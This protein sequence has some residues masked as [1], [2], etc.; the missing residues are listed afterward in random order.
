[1]RETLRRAIA[2]IEGPQA[3][4][5][6]KAG[7]SPGWH[8]GCPEADRL[9]PASGLE[10]RGVHEVKAV[11]EGRS[12]SAAAWMTS[13][14]FALRLAA[15]RVSALETPLPS[16]SQ[17]S[18]APARPWLMWCWP[19]HLSREFG[20]P[21]ALGLKRLSLDPSRL[22]IVETAS[23][24][25]ALGALEEGLRSGSLA[26]AFGLFDCVE[27]TPSRRLSL[28]AQEH[29]TPCLIITH[30]GRAPAPAAATRWRVGRLRSAPHPLVPR[31]PGGARFSLALERCRARPASSAYPPL[32]LE[33]C[34]ETRCFSSAAVLA[35]RPAL[36]RRTHSRSGA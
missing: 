3:F 27:L 36:P 13:I 9:L 24:A 6:S 25:E 20:A 19:R 33:W 2:R 35:D 22:L 7:A 1:V 21:S 18:C 4:E 31:L 23:D 17:A 30:P 15:R 34:D 8:L 12:A 16:A 32:S 11:Q 26:L 10:T 14:G 5:V 28:M 29:R